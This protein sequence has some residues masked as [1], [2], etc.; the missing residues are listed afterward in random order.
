MSESGGRLQPQPHT[1]ADRASVWIVEDSA[2]YRQSIQ[3]LVNG[4]DD[5]QCPYAFPSAEDFLAFITDH[6][7][8]EVVLVDIGLPGLNGIEVVRRVHGFSPATQLVMLT[9]HEDTDRVFEAICAG[10]HGYLLKTAEPLD[11]VASI[12]EVLRGG[13][14]MTSQIARRVLNLFTQIRAPR[15]D[16][17]LTDR[18]RDVLT[19]LVDGKSKKRIAATLSIS[20]HTV[21]THMRSI[22]A[23]L[24]VHSRTRAVVKALRENLVPRRE[25][26]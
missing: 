13:V 1:P 24:H 19:H 18:E 26:D 15:W 7:A 20:Q 10:A 14:P 21:D 11:I 12:R 22:Y 17:Q 25:T 23:K 8:P 16:Y 4:T 6:F 2:S 9:I 3:E 5:L